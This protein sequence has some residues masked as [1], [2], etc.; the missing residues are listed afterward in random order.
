MSVMP[1]MN[2]SAEDRVRSRYLDLL[3]RSL[4]NSIHGES[5]LEMTLHGFLQRIRQPYLTRRGVFHWPLRAHSMIGHQRLRNVRELVERTLRENVPGD[6]IE[7][8]VWRGGACIMMRGVLEAHGVHDR[9]VIC[10]DSF[11][12]LPRP[13]AEKYPADRR[14]RLFAFRELAVSVDEVRRNFAA[15]DLL[16][17]QVVFLK[18]F[19]K[20]TLPGLG[21]RRFA[22]IRLDGDMYE[23]T[24][25]ALVNLYDRLSDHG[26]V[27]VDDYGALKNCARA[28]HD[29]LD[30]R[31]LRPAITAIDDSGIW[32]QKS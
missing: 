12:G 17:E 3:E 13:N 24:M 16:D 2:A 23:S 18:G 11:E 20:D 7:T 25:D 30:Q 8:G 14:D 5:K 26:I 27:I 6:Y 21:N 29:F 15:Y 10:A 9:Q 31:S 4:L 22:L 32:W 19:F 28:V 1:R